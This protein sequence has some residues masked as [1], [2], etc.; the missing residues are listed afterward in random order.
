MSE[1]DISGNTPLVPLSSAEE[2][3]EGLLSDSVIVLDWGNVGAPCRSRGRI[4]AGSSDFRYGVD[5]IKPVCPR[6][7]ELIEL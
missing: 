1:A 4:G 2:E 6:V 5:L 7:S 3:L